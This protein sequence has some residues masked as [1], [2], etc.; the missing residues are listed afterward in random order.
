MKVH[1]CKCPICKDV[2]YSRARH[3]F[4][5]CSCGN[6]FVDGGFD[7][8]RCAYDKGVGAPFEIEVD[9]TEQELFDDWNIGADK[10]GKESARDSQ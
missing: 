7:Y 10:Y 5:S 1:A 8:F 3:D 4:R 6:M 9:A 2:V